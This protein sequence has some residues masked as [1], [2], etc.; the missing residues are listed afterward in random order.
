MTAPPLGNDIV[1]LAALLRTEITCDPHVCFSCLVAGVRRVVAERD[2]Q[3][4]AYGERAGCG[5]AVWNGAM[6]APSATAGDDDVR[7]V[8]MRR[9]RALRRVPEAVE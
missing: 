8:S 2:R 3:W 1:R 4:L 9:D 5:A 7:G 6:P